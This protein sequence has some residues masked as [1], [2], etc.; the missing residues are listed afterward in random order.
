[1]QIDPKQQTKSE[2]Y[3]L[4]IGCV[5]PR[6]IAFV[7][8]Q[9][10]HNIVNA[11]PFS[12]FSAVSSDPPMISI[13]CAR[14]DDGQ[15]KDTARNVIESKEFVV[16]IVD[17]T[18]VKEINETSIDFPSDISEV[19]IV[20]FNLLPSAVVK[21]PRIAQSKVHMECKLQHI[22]Y[23][24]G[25]DKAPSTDLLIGEIVQF[26]ID[27]KLYDKGRILTELL[28]PVARLAGTMYC[29][30]GDTFSFPRLSYEKWLESQIDKKP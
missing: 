21:V 5:L 3:K 19:E 17:G 25:N 4:L 28:D 12:F 1:M 9:N 23:L 29:K 11:A 15:M 2:N 20:G 13:A 24:G 22:L 8:S 26:H 18:N 14:K 10:N 30:I 7:T 16:H 6:P 27:D